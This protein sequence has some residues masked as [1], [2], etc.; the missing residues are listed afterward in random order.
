[1]G[2]LPHLIAGGWVAPVPITSRAGRS[3]TSGGGG[4]AVCCGDLFGAEFGV[5]RLYF[6][7]V[8]KCR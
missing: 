8:D 7:A 6:L 4:S 2:S 5:T 3:C 1:M